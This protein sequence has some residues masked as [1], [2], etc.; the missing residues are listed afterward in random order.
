[1]LMQVIR[2]G[3]HY[4]YVKDFMLDS[5]I[6]S[7]NIVKFKR[8]TGWVTIGTDPIRGRKRDNAANV[9]DRRAVKDR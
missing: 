9:T 2:T 7:K 6:E 8:V 3:N 1:M 4:D 5:L